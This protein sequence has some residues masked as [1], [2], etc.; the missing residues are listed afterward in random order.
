MK[1]KRQFTLRAVFVVI[2]VVALLANTARWGYPHIALF[3][4]AS[5]AGS[6]FSRRFW[7]AALGGA[8]GGMLLTIG[9]LTIAFVLPTTATPGA[10]DASG[11]LELVIFATVSVLLT[12]CVLGGLV[13]SVAWFVRYCLSPK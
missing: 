8:A 12:T 13:G 9:A 10:Q 6:L 3:L 4:G 5:I 11:N 1:N 2:L 7:L